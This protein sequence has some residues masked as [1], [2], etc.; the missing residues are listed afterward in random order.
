MLFCSCSKRKYNFTIVAE[1]A[2]NIQGRS[3]KSGILQILL[4]NYTAQLK[5]NRFYRNKNK[6]AEEHNNFF[7]EMAVSGDESLS[8]GPEPLEGLRHGV[9][10]EEPHH[11]HDL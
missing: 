8:T 11:F 1:R 10:V 6:L 4:K 3:D 9:P 7:N 2:L 5:I